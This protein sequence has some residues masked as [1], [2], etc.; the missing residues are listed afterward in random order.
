MEKSKTILFSQT[1]EVAERKVPLFFSFLAE[2]PAPGVRIHY[3]S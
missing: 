3:D 2:E 1:F